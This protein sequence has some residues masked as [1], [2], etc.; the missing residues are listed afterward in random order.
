MAGEENILKLSMLEERAKQTEQQLTILNQQI[1]ELQNMSL[2]LDKLKKSKGK[3]ILANLG[4]NIFVKTKLVDDNPIV[5]VGSKVLVKKTTA[6]TK[7]LI[8]EQVIEADKLKQQLLE[9]MASINQEL[10][11]LMIEIQ[12]GREKSQGEEK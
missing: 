5:D 9:A 3:E 1:M 8:E 12:T 6:E 4:R 10:E 2:N 11:K 7:K